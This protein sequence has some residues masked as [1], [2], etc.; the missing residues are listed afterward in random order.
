MINDEEYVP[1]NPTLKETNSFIV[2]NNTYY[3]QIREKIVYENPISCVY[4]Y[5]WVEKPFPSWYIEK[6]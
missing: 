2:V 4:I 6:K 3:E 1:E 5:R